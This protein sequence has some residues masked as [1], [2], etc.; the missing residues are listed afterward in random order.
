MKKVFSFFTGVITGGVIGAVVALLFAPMKGTIL[1]ARLHDYA[2]EV[3]DEVK[4]AAL[5]KRE[6]L[7]SKLANLRK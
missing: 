4:Q 3:S 1:R 2:V 5:A 7:E 6:E